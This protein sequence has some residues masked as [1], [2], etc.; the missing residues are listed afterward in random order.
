M[1]CTYHDS[2]MSRP[3]GRHD[4]A[5]RKIPRR[6][7]QHQMQPLGRLAPTVHDRRNH[8]RSTT[9]FNDPA[10]ASYVKKVGGDVMLVDKTR[11]GVLIGDR[12]GLLPGA[13]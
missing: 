3:V 8:H 2:A 4:D 7:V 12:C 11:T 1:T 5:R 10:A 9:S 6:H 13:S